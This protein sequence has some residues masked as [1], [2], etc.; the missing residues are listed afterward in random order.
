MGMQLLFT[1]FCAF[2]CLFGCL[3]VN[4]KCS[5]W[6]LIKFAMLTASKSNL[7]GTLHHR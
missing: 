3:N 1:T 7:L 4:A 6:K 2:M 5:T